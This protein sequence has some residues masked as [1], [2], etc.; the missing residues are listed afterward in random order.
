MS[1]ELALAWTNEILR[2]ASTAAYS[3]QENNEQNSARRSWSTSVRKRSSSHGDRGLVR[4]VKHHRLN[5]AL[6]LSDKRL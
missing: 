5:P 4:Y 3:I 1:I 2:V 6:A